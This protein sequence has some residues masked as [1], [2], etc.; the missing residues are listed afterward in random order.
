MVPQPFF[1]SFDKKNN[2]NKGMPMGS[3]IVLNNKSCPV[4]SILLT[5]QPFNSYFV[6]DSSA[7]GSVI[8]FV[9]VKAPS[10]SSMVNVSPF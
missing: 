7:S 1:T 2:R 3:I 6:A 10:F 5:G 8:D 9:T 4:S